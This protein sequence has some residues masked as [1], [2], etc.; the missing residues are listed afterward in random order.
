MVE[1]ERAQ[2]SRKHLFL[3]ALAGSVVMLFACLP[4]LVGYALYGPAFMG[5]PNGLDLLD[6]LYY[7]ERARAGMDGQL[8]VSNLHT[9]ELDRLYPQVNPLALVM[10]LA[11]RAAGLP[12]AAYPLVAKLLFGSL[13]L[14]FLG[15]LCLRVFEPGERAVGLCHAWAAGGLFWTFELIRPLAPDAQARYG[16]RLGTLR[17]E[18]DSFLTFYSQAHLSLAAVLLLAALGALLLCERPRTGIAAACTALLALIHPYEVITLGAVSLTWLLTAW[19]SARDRLPDRSRAVV[20]TLAAAVP[21]FLFHYLTSYHTTV[22]QGMADDFWVGPFDFAFGFGQP[23]LFALYFLLQAGRGQAGPGRLPSDTRIWAIWLLLAPFLLLNPLLYFRRKLALGLAVPIAVLGARGT[24]LFART[25]C[26][27]R[28]R[29]AAAALTLMT[30]LACAT[31]I[32]V[33]VRD[34]AGIRSGCFPP[35]LPADLHQVALWLGREGQIGGTVLAQPAYLAQLLPG[36][37][38]RRVFLGWRFQTADPAEKEREL[39]RFLDAATPGNER[40]A[41]LR[42]WGIARV[43]LPRELCTTLETQRWPFLEQLAAFGDFV[44]YGV[45]R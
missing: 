31:S 28:P 6:S 30:F 40:A 39:Q 45:R 4:E 44:I 15:W 16:D 3:I 14:A 1:P 36:I 21:P 22:S 2:S 8:F 43:V 35:V 20:L 7:V 32:D 25:M 5:V 37:A 23:L 19:W 29:L 26:Q 41:F 9:P 33:V 17:P 11:L 42:R 18:S 13:L 27:N 12:A 10:G 24:L 34:V 38:G